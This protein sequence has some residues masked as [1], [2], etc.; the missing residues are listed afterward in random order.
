MVGVTLLHDSALINIVSLEECI[1]EFTE[2]KKAIV[3]SNAVWS[4]IGAGSDCPYYRPYC[5]IRFSYEFLLV[6]LLSAGFGVGFQ[7]FFLFLV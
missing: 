7:G 4:V 5:I 3:S 2:I 6:Y 1:S